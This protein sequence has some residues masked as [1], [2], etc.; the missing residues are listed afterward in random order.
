M[1][2][3]FR[4]ILIVHVRSTNTTTATT[5]LKQVLATIDTFQ[6]IP[7]KATNRN[8]SNNSDQTRS[9]KTR[10]TV[11]Q[12]SSY[13]KTMLAKLRQIQSQPNPPP[14]KTDA[15]R[16]ASSIPTPLHK[17]R[18][19][20][21]VQ[22]RSHQLKLKKNQNIFTTINQHTHPLPHHNDD[23][24]GTLSDFLHEDAKQHKIKTRRMSTT[25]HMN[26]L[27]KRTQK[28][29][30]AAT[31]AAGL[32]TRTE[33]QHTS[34]NV[35]AFG[36]RAAKLAR[37]RNAR[38]KHNMSKIFM[39]RRQKI[40][41]RREQEMNAAKN[42]TGTMGGRINNVASSALADSE[43]N[44]RKYKRKKKIAHAKH[45][46]KG[47]TRALMASTNN[48]K[49]YFNQNKT[50]TAT[51][52]SNNDDAQNATA[53]KEELYQK[54]SM[55][56]EN[57]DSMK[58]EQSNTKTTKVIT[59]RE[60]RFLTACKMRNVLPEP[61][62]LFSEPKEYTEKKKASS[63]SSKKESKQGDDGA[64][65]G[66]VDGVVDGEVDGSCLE[67][68]DVVRTVLRLSHRSLS[69]D[70]VASLGECL[71]NEDVHELYMNDNCIL[72]N[73]LERLCKS[74]YASPVL[75][76]FNLS[77]NALE[78]YIPEIQST[79][80]RTNIDNNNDNDNDENNETFSE[81]SSSDSDFSECSDEEEESND[82]NNNNNSH[83]QWRNPGTVALKKLISHRSCRLLVLKLSKMRMG[84][85]RGEY[86]GKALTTR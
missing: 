38:K 52:N 2:L 62:L 63:N 27:R 82:N 55:A 66:A 78:K 43:M 24:C 71:S 29:T 9:S 32:R 45:K 70:L 72:E 22:H 53:E 16:L 51:I 84:D 67:Q 37:K 47:F 48:L 7:S 46:L 1:T 61:I 68:E 60:Q 81:S 18:K 14:Q 11:T 10:S 65:D 75:T 79:H 49:F 26:D 83:I 40:L 50:E 8:R 33:Q 31:K 4:L 25:N 76:H 57:M 86:L 20:I 19:L 69:N 3:E 21:H 17:N 12:K 80:H 44:E 39:V 54:R 58:N 64:V 30:D 42:N 59:E 34:M 73:G 6:S 23:Q 5:E 13:P 35:A 74:Q 41:A 85:V 15:M 28:A 36:A 77:R 56:L